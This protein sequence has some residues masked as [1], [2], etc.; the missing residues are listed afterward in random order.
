M[1]VFKPIPGYEGLY[2]ISNKCRVKALKK[3]VIRDKVGEKSY[4]E[5]ILTINKSNQVTLFKNKKRSYH[6][7]KKMYMKVFEGKEVLRSRLR[8]L[9]FDGDRPILTSQRKICAHAK[10]YHK[11]KRCKLTG[12]SLNTSVGKKYM[13]S[14]TINKKN[15]YLGYFDTEKEANLMYRKAEKYPYLLQGSTKEFRNM[16]HQISI[17]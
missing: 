4:P 14:I 6:C 11:T 5:K 12:V 10:K 15:I 16:L 17:I 3:I 13:S 7:V 9:T 2:E 8:S 1:E